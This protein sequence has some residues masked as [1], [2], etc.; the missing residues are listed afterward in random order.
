LF[1]AAAERDTDFLL[2]EI[3]TGNPKW[4]KQAWSSVAIALYA[5][6]R[7]EEAVRMARDYVTPPSLPP[8]PVRVDLDELLEASTRRPRD[9][10]L[11]YGL[12]NVYANGERYDLALAALEKITPLPECPVYF[13]FLEFDALYRLQKWDEAW[14]VWQNY[15][16]KKPATD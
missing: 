6:G 8:R 3:V 15:W 13:Y 5:K 10:A 4:M 11:A 7:T 1:E 2:S 14:A 12:Y 16:K 9:P